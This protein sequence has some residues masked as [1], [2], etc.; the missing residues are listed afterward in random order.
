[1]G[2]DNNNDN[3]NNILLKKFEKVNLDL[4]LIK[5]CY[6]NSKLQKRIKI[7]CNYLVKNNIK[8]N[9]NNIDNLYVIKKLPFVDNND[10]IIN[11][12]DD[13]RKYLE[14]KQD[15]NEVLDYLS[16]IYDIENNDLNKKYLINIL[17]NHNFL[18][19]YYSDLIFFD[20]YNDILL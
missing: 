19:M 13:N 3:N 16:K 2:D 15:F 1:M 5:E 9:S 18:S 17:I 20:K 11:L 4:D 7:K 10:N 8:L 6:H 12:S 14:S